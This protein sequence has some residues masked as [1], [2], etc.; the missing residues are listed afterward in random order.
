MVENVPWRWELCE[1]SDLR[2]FNSTMGMEG[3]SFCREIWLSCS[4]SCSCSLTFF[5]LGYTAKVQNNYYPHWKTTNFKEN[6]RKRR[7]FESN[8]QHHLRIKH[9]WNLYVKV[10]NQP[11]SLSLSLSSLAS[12]SK[13]S[14][15]PDAGLKNMKNPFEKSSAFCCLEYKYGYCTHKKITLSFKKLGKE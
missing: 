14:K 4:C 13:T 12:K 11:T 5:T 9:Q 15:D 6:L 2:T 10:E 3:L 8:K 7:T 1:E